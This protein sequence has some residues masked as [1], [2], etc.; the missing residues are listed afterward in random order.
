MQKIPLILLPGLMCDSAVWKHQI[1]A[2]SN[3]ADCAVMDYGD[4][5]SLPAMAELVLQQAPEKFAVAGASMG[6]R[7]AFEVFRKAADRV[8]H[9]ALFDTNYVPLAAGEAG[10]QEKRGRIEL[11]ELAR[12]KGMRV[13]SA[14]WLQGMI[15]DYRQTDSALVEE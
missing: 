12:A 15:P 4:L 10:Q 2:L 13:M 14:K 1:A 8:S 11:L 5:D 6:G 7:V 9:I 3:I